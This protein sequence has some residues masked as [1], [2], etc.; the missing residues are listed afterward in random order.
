MEKIA[1]F[2]Q[3]EQVLNI[4]GSIHEHTRDL[5]NRSEFDVK[6]P[7]KFHFQSKSSPNKVSFNTVITPEAKTELNKAL[8]YV[9]VDK[10]AETEIF[11]AKD[12]DKAEGIKIFTSDGQSVKPGTVLGFFGGHMMG[13]KAVEDT[14]TDLLVEGSATTL[15][16]EPQV[17]IN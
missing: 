13:H 1:F 3:F 16:L 14:D 10:D 17:Y 8:N 2:D 11:T 4:F 12:L 9:M 6:D 7:D 15:K 5:K